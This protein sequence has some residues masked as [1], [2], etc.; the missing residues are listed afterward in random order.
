MLTGNAPATFAALDTSLYLS[1]LDPLLYGI[2]GVRA[3]MLIQQ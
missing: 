2:H 3:Q 1:P